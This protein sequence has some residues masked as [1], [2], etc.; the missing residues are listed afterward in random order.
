VVQAEAGERLTEETTMRR[1]EF[2]AVQGRHPHGFLGA[3]LARVM[4]NETAA[5]NRQAIALLGLREGDRVLDVGTGHG[6]SL[7][8]IAGLAPG[9]L[10]VGV[11]GSTVALNIAKQSQASLIRAGRV[12]VECAKSDAL[13]FADASFD[14]A[15][16]VH[17]LYFWDP[18]E[19]HLGEIA[20]VLKPNGKFVL[21]FR[22]AEDALV[23]QKFP[24]SVYA[25]RTIA[26]V[27]SLLAGA[28]F[29]VCRSKRRDVP[30]DSMVWIAARKS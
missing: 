12:R 17:T 27:E 28:G 11:D 3:I 23:T 2:I 30:G 25:F 1:P 19:P 15:M 7:G 14:R 16:A 22:P 10:A 20:R 18:A 13:P 5:D 21:G 26:Q 24:A 29:N 6:R 9:G 8:V 4:A